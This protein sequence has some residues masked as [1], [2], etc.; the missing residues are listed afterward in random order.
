MCGIIFFSKERHNKKFND[1]VKNNFDNYLNRIINRR[2]PDKI[3]SI[4]IQDKSLSWYFG[5][6][7]LAVS[8]FGSKVEQP[9]KTSSGRYVFL[10]NG[11]LYRVDKNKPTNKEPYCDTLILSKMIDEIGPELTFSKIEGM[12]SII[13]ADLINNEVWA[14]RDRFGQKPL[15]FVC[16][17]GGLSIGSLPIFLNI[18]QNKGHNFV[19]S[20]LCNALNYGFHPGNEDITCESVSRVRAGEIIKFKFDKFNRWLVETSILPTINEIPWKKNLKSNESQSNKKKLKN[21]LC[22][23]IELCIPN[24][25]DFCTLLSGGIDSTLI[26]S[27]LA[28]EFGYQHTCFTASVEGSKNNET[29]IARETSKKLNLNHEELILTRSDIINFAKHS[30]FI[31]GEFIFESSQAALFYLYK[32]MNEMGYRVCIG[33][34]GGDEVFKGYRRYFLPDFTHLIP[35][36]VLK[37]LSISFDKLE[38]VNSFKGNFFKSLSRFIRTISNENLFE[39]YSSLLRR[40]F[41]NNKEFNPS[42]NF[43]N[44]IK[45]I[46][47][48]KKNMNDL[49]RLLDIFN[50]FPDKMMQKVD[51]VS[52][53]H[54]IEARTPLIDDQLVDKYWEN[55]SD[56]ESFNISKKLFRDILHDY[57]LSNVSKYKKMGFDIKS[58]LKNLDDIKPSKLSQQLFGNL[59]VFSKLK[60]IN[61]NKL[62][63]EEKYT[64]IAVLKTENIANERL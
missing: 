62:G 55:F 49:N 43:N 54:G 12:Y 46:Y 48:N 29:N 53:Y 42:P 21:L 19:N 56:S 61:F 26:N 32:K 40:N 23:S 13:I 2:G 41:P 16:N 7:L 39:R 20:S 27:I 11:N 52:M 30:I 9:F 63:F 44:Y 45:F 3:N 47:S 33:G 24:N 15:Y 17:E 64:S 14:T 4:E 50:Y 35:S 36:I 28:N 1:P 51:R 22:E 57:G 59:P 10:F 25:L 58:S 60:N 38:K 31:N 34:D 8:S 6:T 18:M 37:S 5:H